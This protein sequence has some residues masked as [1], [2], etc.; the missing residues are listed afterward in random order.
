M[1]FPSRC[2]RSRFLTSLLSAGLMGVSPAQADDAI[3]KIHQ[4]PSRSMVRVEAGHRTGSG[5][6]AGTS[7]LVVTAASL[8][9]QASE[10]RIRGC[11]GLVRLPSLL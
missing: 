8:V 6:F 1:E 11:Y 7:E 5:S 2:P 10:R 3:K 4:Q 9:D